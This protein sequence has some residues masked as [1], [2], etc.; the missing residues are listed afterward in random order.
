MSTYINLVF[1]YCRTLDLIFYCFYTHG[2]PMK[3]HTWW[4]QNSTEMSSK[5]NLLAEEQTSDP[6]SQDTTTKTKLNSKKYDYGNKIT[7]QDK[8]KFSARSIGE[9]A[10]EFFKTDKQAS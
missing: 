5:L 8:T 9:K 10:S 2:Y 6:V 1:N 4:T 3:F 7:R